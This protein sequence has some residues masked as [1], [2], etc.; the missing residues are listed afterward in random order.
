MFIIILLCIILLTIFF[1]NCL[2]LP[3]YCSFCVRVTYLP[4]FVLFNQA[5]V[6]LYFWLKMAAL[7]KTI[8]NNNNQA[9]ISLYFC[10]KMAAL[11]KTI[12]KLKKI[13]QNEQ[14]SMKFYVRYHFVPYNFVNY[15][16]F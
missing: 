3:Q 6:S 11:S 14:Y 10:L 12:K 8:K 5:V 7:S 16:F 9:V 1:L 2:I 15:I 13:S 4:T